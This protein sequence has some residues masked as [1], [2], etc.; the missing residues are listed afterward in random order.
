MAYVVAGFNP[1]EQLLGKFD[2]FPKH[3]WTL[4]IFENQTQLWNN[5]NSLSPII[6]IYT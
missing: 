3:G 1:S 4:K 5:P 2:Y 6:Y